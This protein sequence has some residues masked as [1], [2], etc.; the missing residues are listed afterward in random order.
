MFFFNWGGGEKDSVRFKNTA[1][2][3]T[4]PESK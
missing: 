1:A 4:I 2:A 3:T